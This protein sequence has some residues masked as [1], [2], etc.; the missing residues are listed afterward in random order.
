MKNSHYNK[1]AS[2]KIFIYEGEKDGWL[3]SHTTQEKNKCYISSNHNGKKGMIKNRS[4][5]EILFVCLLNS[6]LLHIIVQSP[7]GCNTMV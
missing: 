4:A 6:Y 5:S 7:V 1:P 2:N 3:F